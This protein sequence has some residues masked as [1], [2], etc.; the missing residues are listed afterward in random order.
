MF[1]DDTKN[2][3][4]ILNRI[5]TDTKFLMEYVRICVIY[6]STASENPETAKMECL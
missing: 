4:D 5:Q 2:L 3:T 1:D 6:D